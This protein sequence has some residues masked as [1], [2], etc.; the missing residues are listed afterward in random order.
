MVAFFNLL[1]IPEDLQK[2]IISKVRFPSIFFSKIA[3]FSSLYPIEGQKS[4]P[5]IS[6]ADGADMWLLYYWEKKSMLYLKD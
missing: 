6:V 4:S 5:S 1:S 3:V 2:K